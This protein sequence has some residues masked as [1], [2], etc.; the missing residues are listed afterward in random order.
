MGISSP[1][2]P[3]L[4]QP[5]W[6]RYRKTTGASPW[7]RQGTAPGSLRPDPPQTRI[8]FVVAWLPSSC[9]KEDIF[10]RFKLN[11]CHP[12]N[13]VSFI[14]VCVCVTKNERQVCEQERCGAAGVPAL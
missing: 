1:L 7:T 3:A 10:F 12:Y 8:S 11:M 13:R 5:R 4:R 6:K 14:G 2:A 9:W